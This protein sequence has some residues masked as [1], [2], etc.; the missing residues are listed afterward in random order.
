MTEVLLVE[1][2]PLVRLVIAEALRDA[3][4]K[5][6]EAQSGD[7]A[8]SLL[9]RGVPVDV[10]LTDIPMPGRIQGPE[11]IRK[12]RAT[13]PKLTCIVMSANLSGVDHADFLFVLGKPFNLETV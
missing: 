7:E 10:I 11:L 1:D 2:D 6:I 4:L 13:L 9:S 8:W 5:V 3:E 12:A